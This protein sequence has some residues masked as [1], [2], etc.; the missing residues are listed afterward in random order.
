MILSKQIKAIINTRIYKYFSKNGIDLSTLICYTRRY[1]RGGN[2]Q[3]TL[4]Q[5]NS[6][7]NIIERLGTQQIEKKV[8]YIQENF[9][10]STKV[11][12]SSPTILTLDIEDESNPHSLPFKLK[13]YREKLGFTKEVFAKNSNLLQLD[14]NSH[15][16]TSVIGKIE[17]LEMLGFTLKHIRS[18][19]ILLSLDSDPTSPS[20]TSIRQKIIN[21][22]TMGISDKAWL[23]YPLILAMDCNIKSTSPTSIACKMQFFAKEFGFDGTQINNFSR[24]LGMDCSIETDNPAA[25]INKRDF[26]LN[27]VGLSLIDLAKFPHLLGYDCDPNSKNRTSVSRK[28]DIFLENGIDLEILQKMPLLIGMPRDAIKVRYMLYRVSGL[29]KIPLNS[30]IFVQNECKTYARY[31]Y[32][33]TEIHPQGNFR[34][35]AYD[36]AKFQRAFDIRT[37]DLMQKYPLDTQALQDLEQQYANLPSTTQPIK[38][39]RCELDYICAEKQ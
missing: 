1:K 29:D 26:Y 21:L 20:P 28:I 32:L 27:R 12:Y 39:D 10:L 11:I 3:S 8:K 22:K 36:E 18:A 7:E 16:Q 19:P 35:I 25:L 4:R 2:M 13:F 15:S 9:G 33:D 14:C 17:S 23:S 6:L 37:T 30:S 34:P 5:N 24:L 38:L 31:K